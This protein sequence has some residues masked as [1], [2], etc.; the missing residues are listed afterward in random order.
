MD[1]LILS[2]NGTRQIAA[3]LKAGAS[4][5][6][7]LT[8]IGI[9]K[10]E[11]YLDF[12]G[13][14]GDRLLRWNTVRMVIGDTISFVTSDVEHVDSPLESL[15][16]KEVIERSRGKPKMI[17][18][19]R[20]LANFRDAGRLSCSINDKRLFDFRLTSERML[21]F[22]FAW[23]GDK[24][25]ESVVHAG[26]DALPRLNIPMIRFGDEVSF[27]TSGTGDGNEGVD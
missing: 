19:K 23:L 5:S 11:I 25:G 24:A 10:D 7:S 21:D 8:W 14:D 18:V 22:E 1:A 16:D 15:T 17:P 20:A 6:I 3:E 12:S 4:V 2:K 26:I 13:R 9:E 27:H